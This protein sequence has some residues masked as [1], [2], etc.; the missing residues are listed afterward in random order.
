MKWLCK[1]L[2]IAAVSIVFG[3]AWL[4][5]L[6]AMAGIDI[7][8]VAI[9]FVIM[10]S[11]L[12]ALSLVEAIGRKVFGREYRMDL[13]SCLVMASIFMA[14]PFTSIYLYFIGECIRCGETYW[15]LGFGVLV[16]AVPLA[17]IQSRTYR[18]LKPAP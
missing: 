7:V 13:L 17:F 6:G 18:W 5:F 15:D 10:A 4:F 16:Y 12:P 2:V 1:Q 9:L 8:R 14:I 11:L 3:A